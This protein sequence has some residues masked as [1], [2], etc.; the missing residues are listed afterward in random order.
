MD[1]YKIL[2]S[3]KYYMDLKE[4]LH[5]ISRDL[6]DPLAA[7]TLL[8]KIEK[9]IFSLSTMPYRY[10]IIDDSYLAHKEFRKCLIKNFII[11]YK[12][13]EESKT[14]MIHRILQSRQKT[15]LKFYKTCYGG[16]KWQLNL[17]TE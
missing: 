10:S 6:S 3:E 2:V 8:D 11:F 13:D 12:V 17:E 16:N 9:T 4:I 7:S 14:I 1:H 5:Y 15:G